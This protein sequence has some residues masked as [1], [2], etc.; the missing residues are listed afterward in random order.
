MQNN[1]TSF[2][3]YVALLLMNHVYLYSSLKNQA[4]SSSPISNS[5]NKNRSETEL[6]Q[7]KVWHNIQFTQFK[8]K[9]QIKILKLKENA[10]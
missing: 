8:K 9:K 3:C 6:G 2:L 4:Y 5:S 10:K 7:N 1:T